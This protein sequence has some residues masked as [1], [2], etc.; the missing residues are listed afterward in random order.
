MSMHKVMRETK[1]NRRDTVIHLRIPR[2]LKLEAQAEAED[3]NMSF[4]RW[5]EN[6]IRRALK[7]EVEKS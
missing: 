7:K 2:A 1:P 3:K 6:L 4:T 5:L